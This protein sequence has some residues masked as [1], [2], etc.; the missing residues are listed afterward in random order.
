MYKSRFY[1]DIGANDGITLSN[2]YLLEKRGWRGICIEANKDIF[3][4][5]KNN[6]KCYCYNVAFTDS[7][8]E[9]LFLKVNGENNMLS[10]IIESDLESK[11]SQ[12]NLYI[13]NN[14][15]IDDSEVVKVQGMSF[16]SVMK[17]HNIDIIDYISIDV[18]GRELKILEAIDFEKYKILLLTIENNNKKDRTIRDFMQSRGYKCIKRL[19]QDEVY[20]RAD[21]L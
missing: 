6:R 12:N 14:H 4:L 7:D 18:E 15:K 16:D 11:L 13:K 8:K 2:T 3:T 10:G 17:N 1:I 21:S 5:L 9:V 19:T 20:A